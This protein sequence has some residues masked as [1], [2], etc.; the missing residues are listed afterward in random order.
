[1]AEQSRAE[2]AAEIRGGD[3]EDRAWMIDAL[4]RAATALETTARFM[5]TD[6]LEALPIG[7]VVM[8]VTERS[9]GVYEQRV[10]QKFGGSKDW[11]FGFPRHEWQSTDGGFVRTGEQQRYRAHFAHH[12]AV[13]VLFV[14]DEATSK[15]IASAHSEW[16][17]NSRTR[18]NRPAISSNGESL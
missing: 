10:W 4:E 15:R 8:T 14:P 9:F 2:L 6:E 18:T 13:V 7:S 5:P 1:M 11:Q 16:L 17:A 12:R 3:M